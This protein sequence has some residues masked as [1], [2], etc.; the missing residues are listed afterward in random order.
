V[1]PSIREARAAL[2]T[3]LQRRNWPWDLGASLAL[4]ALLILDEARLM[5][6]MKRQ[7]QPLDDA[8]IQRGL[9]ARRDAAHA[10]QQIPLCAR[11][12][13]ALAERV[14]RQWRELA[15]RHVVTLRTEPHGDGSASC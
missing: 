2:E 7:R 14:S 13:L 11:E 9:A 15:T 5:P 10:P 1:A 6:D 4:D 8:A 12:V 3:D